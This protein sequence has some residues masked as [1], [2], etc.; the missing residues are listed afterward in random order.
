MW[1]SLYNFI[2]SCDINSNA[3]T[4]SVVGFCL[5]C[6]VP[7]SPADGNVSSPNTTYGSE[8]SYS[9]N[10]G[11]DMNGAAARTCEA[12]GNWSSSVPTCDIVSE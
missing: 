9:C 10:T 4:F 2:C 11:Y 6:G 5:D 3:F 1:C 8:A 7:A 12:G